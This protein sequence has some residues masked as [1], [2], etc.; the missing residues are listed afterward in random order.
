[1]SEAA[2]AAD[3]GERDVGKKQL[4]EELG[5]SRSRLD[6][7]LDED[8]AFP[9]VSRGTQ[10]GGWKFNV[11]AVREYLQPE[12]ERDTLAEDLATP[13]GLAARSEMTA[14]QRRDLAQAQLHEDKLAR[15]RGDLVDASELRLA[16]AESVSRTG[17]ALNS[18]AD[19]LVRRLNL[20]ES[21]L[22]IIRQEVDGIRRTLV[23]GL[24]EMLTD[25]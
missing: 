12:E 15:M 1:M 11:A 13:A 23:T 25:G 21:A 7:R 20:P 9:V 17:V 4:C 19:V 10:A 6:R 5:W 18:L 2:V 16:L 14:R 8:E 22:P 3:P 24:R